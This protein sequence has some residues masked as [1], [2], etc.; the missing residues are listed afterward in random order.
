[1]S[2]LRPIIY[3]SGSSPHTP[4]TPDTVSKIYDLT[5][6]PA[7]DKIESGEFTCTFIYMY[8]YIVCVCLQMYVYMYI[9][10]V[11]VCV[12]VQ[13]IFHLVLFVSVFYLSP[14]L[15]PSL[16]PSLL[17]FLIFSSYVSGNGS[18]RVSKREL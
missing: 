17:P 12:V 8:N 3:S 6:Y 11:S 15:L 14:S 9:L 2:L 5:H 18:Q 7:L 16:P 13:L 1:M 10:S 4:L